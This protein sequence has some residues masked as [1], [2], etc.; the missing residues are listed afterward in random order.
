MSRSKPRYPGTRRAL[1]LLL[2][3]ILVA[4]GFAPGAYSDESPGHGVTGAGPELPSQELWG[5]GGPT[6][7]SQRALTPRTRLIIRLPNILG[8]LFVDKTPRNPNLGVPRKRPVPVPAEWQSDVPGCVMSALAIITDLYAVG[9]NPGGSPVGE[10]PPTTVHALAFGSIPVTVTLRL[11][12]VIDGQLEPLRADIWPTNG[13]SP[14]CDPTWASKNPYA[15]AYVRGRLSM[16]LADLTIDGQAVDVGLRC[17]TVEPLQINM[18]G[19]RA[20]DVVRPPDA[21]PDWQQGWTPGAGGNLY[22][23]E[24]T[25]RVNVPGGNFVHPGSTDL[26]IPDFTGCVSEDGEDISALITSAISGPGNEI[27]A[28]QAEPN[29][30]GDRSNPA[31]CY[32]VAHMPGTTT[33]CPL[34]PPQPPAIPVPSG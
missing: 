34:D 30:A 28:L 19:E 16:T 24:D 32:P 15:P 12:Q 23:R 8:W 20:G 33:T 6:G 11:S 31:A 22:Q 21:P 5:S 25:R 10:L 18:W 9:T 14:A 29:V 13:A 26:T 3:I 27:A 7:V 2:W 1:I 4:F 17:R